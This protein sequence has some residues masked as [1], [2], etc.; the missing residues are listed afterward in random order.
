[1]KTKPR[2]K[3][4]PAFTA[5]GIQFAKDYSRELYQKHL[6]KYGKCNACGLGCKAKNHVFYR[7]WA[8]CD[9]LFI[10]EAP[11]PD[12]DLLGQP[13]IGR[14]GQLLNDLISAA[15]ERTQIKFK[16][17]FTNILS[18]FPFNPMAP[19]KFRAPQQNEAALCT[20][21]LDSIRAF[22]LPRAYVLCGRIAEQYFTFNENHIRCS[23]QHPSYI[24]RNG[25][26]DTEVWNNNLDKLCEFLNTRYPPF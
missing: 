14:A 20:E 13:F 24:V 2:L 12:E 5:P 15:M 1:M 6:W 25:G 9:V 16:C 22:A 8:P 4:N 17:G 11:G 19:S 10:G 7:G 18:C 23:I 21:V 26:K 3:L